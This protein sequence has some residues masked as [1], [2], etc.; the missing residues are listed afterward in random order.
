M[1]GHN[2]PIHEQDVTGR[3]LKAGT[4]LRMP[5]AGLAPDQRQGLGQRGLEGGGLPVPLSRI[6]SS[7]TVPAESV[8]DAL[9]SG[10]VLMLSFRCRTVP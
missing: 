1:I 6:A 4:D 7:R 3:A 10:C 8:E 2:R 5:A 9:D